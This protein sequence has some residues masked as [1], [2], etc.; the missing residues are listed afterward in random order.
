MNV[1]H[2]VCFAVAL[3]LAGCGDGS[4]D[5]IA[6]AEADAGEAFEEPTPAIEISDPGVEF[7]PVARGDDAGSAD[8]PPTP[9]APSNP[10]SGVVGFA[11]INLTTT[12]GSCG[13]HA[14]AVAAAS[15][16]GL[17]SAAIARDIEVMIYGYDGMRS[18]PGVTTVA[19]AVNRY[20]A[21]RSVPWKAVV[22]HDA[23]AVAGYVAKGSPVIANT[24]QWGGHYVAIYGLKDGQ[25]H[26]SDGTYN[27]G[28]TA[29]LSTGYL[30]RWS[31][32]TFLA[33][34][35]GNFIGFVPTTR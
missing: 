4:L 8:A 29:T 5:E 3:L 10:L 30:K 13:S 34:S 24:S 32:S 12:A 15:L 35:K 7:E 27:D 11:Q 33:Y 14:S 2:R 19:A 16:R 20:L 22:F 26:F 28:V 9:A 31:W 6:V 1:V 25:V 21:Y 17:A 18:R 23:T